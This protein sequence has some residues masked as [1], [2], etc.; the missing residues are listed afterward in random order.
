MDF[1][2]YREGVVANRRKHGFDVVDGGIDGF[3]RVWSTREE[4]PTV[5]HVSVFATL[6]DA[7]DA[8]APGVAAA[9]DR[10][11]E[12]LADLSDG[13][14]SAT[15]IGYVAFVV[16]SADDDLVSAATSYTVAERRTN[17]FPLV[18]DLESG[19]LHTHPVP[20]LKGRGIY[21]RQREDAE[22]LFDV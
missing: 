9:A 19:T 16:D 12:F 10:F 5:G 7:T 4:D 2:R 22:R 14:S 6:V 11:R 20:R 17:V 18:Y 3:D 1:D 21:R 13:T 15:P 8:D